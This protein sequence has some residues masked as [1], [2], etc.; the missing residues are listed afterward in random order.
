MRSAV[1]V[2]RGVMAIRTMKRAGHEADD[3]IVEEFPTAHKFKIEVAPD[4]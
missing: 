3:V 2:E 4:G 1:D